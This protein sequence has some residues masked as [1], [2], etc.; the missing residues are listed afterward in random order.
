MRSSTLDKLLHVYNF[1]IIF[2]MFNE[3]AQ[4]LKKKVFRQQTQLK[5]RNRGM[6]SRKWIKL[7]DPIV[8]IVGTSQN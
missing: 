3:M 8:C 5:E 2:I 4:I 1:L 7:E 6:K